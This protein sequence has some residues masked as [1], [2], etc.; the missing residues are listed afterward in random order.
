LTE[1]YRPLT[2]P[3]VEISVS[4]KLGPGSRAVRF[5]AD[6]ALPSRFE[7]EVLPHAEDALPYALDL[8]VVVEDG[9]PRCEE[10]RA[11]RL[12]GGPPVTAEGLRRVPV[13]SIVRDAAARAALRVERQRRGAKLT[14]IGENDEDF[15]RALR[16]TKARGRTRLTDDELEEVATIYRAAHAR[17]EAPTE[18]VREVLRTSRASAS[19]WIREAR[20][21]GF[22][23]PAQPRRAGG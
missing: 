10:L 1:A 21:R 20:D 23:G 9:A 18:T 16:K 5:G 12:E 14:P 22:L 15:Y 4:S 13:A 19:R 11:S 8:V 3:V 2:V 17:G 6:L 7:V